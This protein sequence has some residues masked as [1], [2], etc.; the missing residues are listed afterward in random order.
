MGGVTPHGVPYVTPDDHPAEFPAHS[1]ALANALENVTF[2]ARGTVTVPVISAGTSSSPFAI[3]FPAGIFTAAPS[4]T[5][6]SGNG[7]L[8]GAVQSISASGASII[9]SNFTSAA[10]AGTVTGYWIAAGR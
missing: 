1:Q 7:R 10:S 3:T 4:L 8:V 6:T 5:L 2:V 9:F